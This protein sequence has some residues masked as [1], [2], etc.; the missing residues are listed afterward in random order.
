[1]EILAGLNM[2]VVS[3]LKESWSHLSQR[4]L[5][6]F[7]E[8]NSLMDHKNNYA[9]YRRRLVADISNHNWEQSPVIPYLGVFLRDLKFCMEV[10]ILVDN[11][12]NF[13][14]LMVMG[15]VLMQLEKLLR[16]P[17]TTPTEDLLVFNF[18]SNLKAMNEDQLYELNKKS[19]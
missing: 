7:D 19:V 5:D 2:V 1:M 3:R 15:D 13:P 18:L 14:Q 16:Q 4:Y 8:L 12:I 10:P 6:V 9:T 11:L 17:C